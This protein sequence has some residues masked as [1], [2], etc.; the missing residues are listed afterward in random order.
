MAKKAL[1]DLFVNIGQTVSYVF[2]TLLVTTNG[3]CCRLAD[4]TLD[5]FDCMVPYSLHSCT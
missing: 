5:S 1:L 4:A 2:P 3:C